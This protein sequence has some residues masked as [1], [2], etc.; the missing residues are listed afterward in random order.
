VQQA[1]LAFA[2]ATTGNFDDAAAAGAEAVT[3]AKSTGS[4]LV[5]KELHGLSRW[6]GTP[7]IDDVLDALVTV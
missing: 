6:A 5:V 3:L 4:M 7:P 1:K 2:H